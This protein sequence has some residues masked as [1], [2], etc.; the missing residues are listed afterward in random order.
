LNSTR[1]EDAPGRFYLRPTKKKSSFISAELRK[2]GWK[3][4]PQ[5]FLDPDITCSRQ[6]GW[7]FFEDHTQKPWKGVYEWKAHWDNSAHE[8]VIYMLSYNAPTN[9]TRNLNN[10]QGI[11]L[12]IPADTTAKM[13][14]RL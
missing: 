8:I 7:T 4:L 12:F 9:S 10:L 5:D 6:R 13:R 1:A 3:P 11:A 2:Q 14:V